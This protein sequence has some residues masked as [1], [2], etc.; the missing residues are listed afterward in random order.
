MRQ[1]KNAKIVRMVKKKMPWA[2]H[3]IED[4]KTALDLNL[5]DVET[6]VPYGSMCPV[7]KGVRMLCHKARC[8]ITTKLY[9]YLKVK[10]ALE[11]PEIDGS[12]PPGIFIGRFGYPRVL[13][14][15]M[16]PPL[17]GNT[18]VYDYPEE[19]F[20]MTIDEIVDFRLRLVRGMH[21]A[22]VR[23]PE[24]DDK[25]LEETRFLAMAE[26]SVDVELNLRYRPRTTFVLNDEVQPMGP[27]APMERM[28][29]GNFHLNPKIEA[30]FYDHDLKATEAT[31]KLYDEGVPVSKLQKALSVG[32]F[33]LKKRRRLVPTRWS[34]TA[35]DSMLSLNLIEKIKNFPLLN[36]YRVY[37]STYLD[38]RFEVIL[39]PESWKYGAIEAW[40]PGTIWNPGRE[41]VFLFGDSESYWGRRTYAQMGGC[42]YAARLAVCELLQRERRQAAALVLREAHPGYIMPV[43]VWQV[44]ENVRNAL[45]NPP[46]KF[47]SLKDVLERLNKRF[48][49]P[50]SA[51]VRNSEHLK[52][53]LRQTKITQFL[54]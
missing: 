5:L 48:D 11:S 52:D 38:N 8:P 51:W 35:V 36:E 17:H 19:W 13:V 10:G 15:P 28:R 43:G 12:S 32:A 24:S 45:R 44:R 23:V 37:E 42:Y 41:D 9:A 46:L 49:I 54:Q 20:G 40:Y 16:V 39:L 26:E 2:A 25:I 14:G 3:L 30:A 18:R 7:C 47:S 33:G 27:S 31:I 34:I 50:L 29:L 21:R 4:A 6:R 1:D 53:A 22:D